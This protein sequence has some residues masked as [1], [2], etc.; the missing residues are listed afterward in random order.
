MIAT[1]ASLQDP[2]PWWA[3]TS[4][5]TRNSA[6]H[7]GVQHQLHTP[8]GKSVASAQL[9]LITEAG[10]ECVPELNVQGGAFDSI[11]LTDVPALGAA[12]HAWADSILAE[13][14][15]VT[16]PPAAAVTTHQHP[17]PPPAWAVETT[18]GVSGRFGWSRHDSEPMRL[19]APSGYVVAEAGLH[20]FAEDGEPIRNVLR[21]RPQDDGVTDDGE[22]VELDAAQT[23]AFIASA[24]IWLDQLRAMRAQMGGGQ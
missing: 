20:L 12:I 11:P 16:A 23:D 14:R 18:S 22:G 13:H 24:E 3:A 21:V 17:V 10:F 7:E 9:S 5:V 15:K 4:E 2:A 19:V 6:I 8:G 1:A